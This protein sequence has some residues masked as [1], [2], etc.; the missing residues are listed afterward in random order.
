MRTSM[1]TIGKLAM[2]LAVAVLL[3]GGLATPAGATPR[4]QGVAQA[5]DFVLGCTSAGGDPV[6]IMDTTGENLTVICRFPDGTVSVCPFLP[7]VKACQWVTPLKAADR[8]RNN[9]TLIPSK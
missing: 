3:L 9:G 6:V 4:S 1:R 5:N 8:T 2:V 7:V